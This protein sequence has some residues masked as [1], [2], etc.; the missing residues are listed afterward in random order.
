MYKKYIRAAAVVCGVLLYPGLEGIGG[1]LRAESASDAAAFENSE[2]AES[3]RPESAGDVLKCVLEHHPDLKAAQSELEG[4]AAGVRRAEQS[5]NPEL[6]SRVLGGGDSLTAEV[7][8]THTFETGGKRDARVNVAKEDLALATSRVTL[9]RQASVI[10]AALQ[11]L[12]LSQVRD[13]IALLNEAAGTYRR[14]IRRLRSRPGLSSEQRVN[15]GIYEVAAGEAALSVV[16]LSLERERL[17]AELRYTSGVAGQNLEPLL[18]RASE[19]KWPTALALAGAD[20]SEELR[21]ARK[22]IARARARLE[23]EEANAFPNLSIG[24]ALEYRRAN[25]ASGGIFGGSSSRSDAELGLSFRLTLPLYHRNDGGRAAASAD[26]AAEQVRESG[27]ADR[28]ALERSRLMQEYER[29][30]QSLR[31]AL[32]QKVLQAKHRGL[33]VAIRR[34]RISPTTVIEFHRNMYEYA[35]TRN[36]QEVG[37]LRALLSIYALN[38]QILSKVED[39]EI[40]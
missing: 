31:K 12:R 2:G 38:G 35:A 40:F 11:L 28:L 7:D 18:A 26:V 17:L 33:Q 19:I 8:F 14:M 37:A 20:Q 23:L 5:P 3:C 10:Q 4:F 36:E 34:G 25:E 32:S 15:L 24:P 6:G 16:G 13:E 9:R 21:L 27:V 1:E 39:Y 22:R 29:A 30:R